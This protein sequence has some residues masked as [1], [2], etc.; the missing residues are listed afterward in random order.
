MRHSASQSKRLSASSSPG[1][2]NTSTEYGGETV[3]LWWVGAQDGILNIADD[4]LNISRAGE[5][6]QIGAFGAACAELTA[7]AH[8]LQ[9]GPTPPA[10]SVNDPFQSAMS[11]LQKA[12]TECTNGLS[13]Q[14]ASELE[15]TETGLEDAATQMQKLYASLDNYLPP[16]SITE[17][18]TPSFGTD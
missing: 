3:A 8:R 14:N 9:N 15:Q 17:P 10:A 16:G 6:E 11:D 1:S 12:G 5:K 2:S 18:S 7:D 13:T 4:L